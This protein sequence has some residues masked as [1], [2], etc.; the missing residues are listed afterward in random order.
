MPIAQSSRPSTSWSAAPNSHN[1]TTGRRDVN[2]T[3]TAER[4][5]DHRP[6][7]R[8]TPAWYRTQARTS[9]H[10]DRGRDYYPGYSRNNHQSD[11]DRETAG[12]HGRGYARDRDRD[13]DR[14]NTRGDDYNRDR[15]HNRDR[16]YGQS[17]Y[18]RGGHVDARNGTSLHGAA[19]TAEYNRGSRERGCDHVRTRE[20]RGGRGAPSTDA[21]DG[22]WD[23]DV[24][25]D[26]RRDDNRDGRRDGSRN[27]GSHNDASRVD[28]TLDDSNRSDGRDD[29]GVYGWSKRDGRSSRY[30]Y[31]RDTRDIVTSSPKRTRSWDDRDR[32]RKR[33]R[34][35]SPPS[36]QRALSDHVSVPAAHVQNADNVRR[37]ERHGTTYNNKNRSNVSQVRSHDETESRR[38]SGTSPTKKSPPKASR[39][40]H[41]PASPRDGDGERTARLEDAVS[42]AQ[43]TAKS[44][45]A[46][47]K[48][49]FKLLYDA[50]LCPRTCISNE[51]LDDLS[52]SLSKVRLAETAGGGED[53]AI[54]DLPKALTNGLRSAAAGRTCTYG[55]VE[56]A[57]MPVVP[58]DG[59]KRFVAYLEWWFEQHGWFGQGSEA[60]STH[61]MRMEDLVHRFQ[62][63]G[64]TYLTVSGMGRGGGT[65]LGSSGLVSANEQ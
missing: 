47:E 46:A 49:A 12:G 61:G 4:D 26:I 5:R 60:S 41:L 1:S 17:H 56:K 21:R 34:Q 44:G 25:V 48:V 57:D 38:K 6:E 13:R 27:D 19:Y 15:A 37:Q 52:S 23:R 40:S 18:K 42:L 22:R 51:A 8:G 7:P 55:G 30:E 10:D 43:Y 14:D 62:G 54:S 53:C 28:S 9:Q 33:P 65:R 36:P 64:W 11:Y 24:E 58:D 39:S 31:S 16:D 45:S 35:S 3:S 20:S 50:L 29:G 59:V 63:Q 2:H 32:S